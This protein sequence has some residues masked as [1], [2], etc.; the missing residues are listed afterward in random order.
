MKLLFTIGII[1]LSA[2][3]FTQTKIIIGLIKDG[4]SDEPISYSSAK[5]VVSKFGK[6]ADSVGKFQF[7]LNAS[8]IDTLE[9]SSVGYA[10]KKYVLI[11]T[12]KDT[13]FIT[14]LLDRS[15]EKEGVQVKSKLGKGIILWRKIV[16]HKPQN[17]RYQYKSFS[18]DLYNKME[19]D[20]V[21]LNKEKIRD[22]K[23]LKPFSFILNNVD[24]TSDSKPFLPIFLTET[25]SKYYLQNDPR[26][27][28]EIITASKTSGIDNESVSKLLGGMYQNVNLYHNFIPVFNT[29][30]V[31]PLSDNGDSYYKYRV[32]DTQMIA[33]KRCFHLTFTPKKEGENT[34]VGDCWVVDTSFAIQKI[35]LALDK[36]ANINYVEKLTM[37]QEFTLLQDSIW[38]VS[39]EKFIANVAPVGKNNLT[40]TGRKTTN[41]SNVKIE[42]ADIAIELKKNKTKEDI[43]LLPDA[44]NK[45]NSFFDTKRPELLSKNEQSIYHLVDTLQN[46]PLFKKYSK[47]INFLTTGTRYVG[48]VII[49]PWYNW[50]SGNF[51]EG[52]RFRFDLGT[53]R[54]FNKKL[55]LHGYIAYGTTDT[56]IKGK[57]EGLYLLNKNPRSWVYAGAVSDYDN[58]QTYYDEVSTDNIFALAIRKP[59]VANK[60]LYVMQKNIEYFKEWSS[61][62]SV[63]AV[64]QQKRFTPIR[65]LPAKENY[66]TQKA[67]YEVLNN[68]ETSVKLRYA[69]LE[70]FLENDFYRTSLGSPYP[71]T[72][73][74]LSHGFAGVLGSAYRYNKVSINVS[75]YIKTPPYG[76]I[77]Y[78][79]FAGKVF[80]S[81]PFTLLEVHPGN[82]IFYY[83]KYAFNMMNRFEYISDT[84]AGLNV[85]HNIGNGM[86]KYIGFT[87]KLKFRQFYNAKILYGKLSDENK[88]INKVAEGAF[89]TIGD[90]AYIEL[91][92]GVDN[93][94]KFLRI[95]CVWRVAP[96]PLPDNKFQRFAV[97][98]SFR[99]T[100]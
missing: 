72:E 28:K 58:G 64:V 14:A 54:G 74:K 36:S 78:N 85:E 65:N 39:K 35:T 68:F 7:V 90:K 82:E 75:D 19:L 62:F 24:S 57:M 51:V 27:S 49:G 69:F 3:A 80:G 21:N 53:N 73:V 89:K 9:I 6:Q 12:E 30:F 32:V 76:S 97:F 44:M 84:Y 92:T 83:N 59:N 91:G 40:V 86:F 8:K 16:K 98:G 100:F 47:T 88:L 45:E 38:F 4:H 25:F 23:I 48:N 5:F 99:V 56:K 66:T 46:M 13:I 52:T 81:L 96:K 33:N 95:D 34:F 1:L 63:Q 79:V 43:I 10:S 11:V 55:K 15:K 37:F 18:Y 26:K 22:I 87:R 20:I 17:D 50:V 29:D 77:Y 93:I 60:F 31:S 2:K 42:D 41:Y 61:G 94:F 70:R 71:I 67:G